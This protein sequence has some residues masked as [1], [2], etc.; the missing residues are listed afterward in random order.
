MA[1]PK[2]RGPRPNNNSPRQYGEKRSPKT[3][4]VFLNALAT[5]KSPTF[6]AQ[7]ADISRQTAYDWREKDQDF[8]RRWHDAVEAGVDKLE[9]EAHRRAVQGCNRPVFQGG[10]E[11]GQICEYSDTLMVLMLKGRRSKVYNTDRVEHVGEG[12]KPIAHSVTVE[13]VKAKPK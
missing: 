2:P 10:I 3:E 13:F 1:R 6:A 7:A 4:Q 8:A 11:V 5:G 9:D 12:G